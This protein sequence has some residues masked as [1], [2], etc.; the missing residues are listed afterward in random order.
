MT[1]K[2]YNI[3]FSG[4]I[5]GGRQ[6]A[7]I[8]RHIILHLKRYGRVL[9]DH[10]GDPELTSGGEP[11]ISDINVFQ[12]DMAWID[13]ADVFVA[14]VTN[15]SLGVG[16]E[17]AQA[18]QRGKPVLCL[19]RPVNVQRLSAMIAG[20]PALVVIRYTKI[21]ELHKQIDHFFSDL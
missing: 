8:Y 2:P 3:Y 10:I 5:S 18:E 12:R 17:L 4:S 14:E 7:D 21:E 11:Q 20:N 9:T 1:N 19:F 16:Y 6:D 13:Q 15:P